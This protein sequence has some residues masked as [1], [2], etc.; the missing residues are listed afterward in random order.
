[1]D[2]QQLL[3]QPDVAGIPG[4]GSGRIAE[5]MAARALQPNFQPIV[6]LHDGSLYGHEALIRTPPGCPW[7]TPDELFAAAREQQLSIE[8]EI[9]CVRQSLLAWARLGSPGPLFLN[10]S[11]A[12]LVTAL[13][14]RDLELIMSLS[15]GSV[16]ATGGV[17]IEL[18]EHEHVADV[19]ALAAAVG[20]LRR[21]RVRVAL[22]DFGDG[23]SSLRL[24][25]EIKPEIVKIDKYFTRDLSN[26]P[27]KLQTL[28]A[29]RQISDTLG[30]ALVAEGIESAVDLHLV[31][32]LGIPLGQGWVFGRPQPRPC[33]EVPL[34]VLKVI[35]SRDVA[36]FPERRRQTQQRANAWT[37]LN[38]APAVTAGTTNQELYGR[39]S[40]DESLQALAIVDD[41]GR[42]LGLVGRQRF[43][44]RYAKPF[45]RE[46]YGRHPCTQ[47]ANLSPRL[48]DIRASIDDLTSVLTSD[49]QRYLSE[50]F[51]IV[52]QGRYR[53]LG[54]G[55]DLVRAVTES[56][57]E[58]AR[59]ANPLT[60]LPGNIPLTQHI[61]RLLT[62][63]REFVACYS[64]LNHFKPFNDQYGYWR[65]DEMIQLAA[66][67]VVAHADARRDF[68][69]HVG[70][71]D[72]VVLFQS[73]DWD[74]RSQ[75]IVDDFNREA[76]ALYDA[77]ARAAGGVMA[78]DRY[79]MQR[80]HPLT[81]MSIGAVRVPAGNG[82][83][84][85]EDVA[86][87]A[88]RAKRQAKAGDA[89]LY[90]LDSCETEPH[91]QRGG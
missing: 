9:E 42:P 63:G 88:A 30:S 13:A 76:L 65:G 56:R 68:V 60:L 2:S 3:F 17:V 66:R 31:R 71:D 50:G 1:M 36:V 78:E 49:D 64:D 5:L 89:G 85:P 4:I 23:R 40:Q 72:F 67:C 73:D 18:T 32:D 58:A 33:D 35:H 79:G 25:S 46:L 77:E 62:A 16:L 24:W 82:T 8:L 53:G 39:F 15:R 59:H 80:F 29:L 27:E 69:G 34:D 90:V 87:A 47:F 10:L 37:L 26:H 12:A 19:D 14:Q 86:N 21:H 22:D 81:T 45:F 75:A 57:I 38:E 7:R 28:R 52:E 54:R 44:D 70:G 74:R 41:D 11:A 48:V 61:Q 84:R 43:V 20:R 51:I 55:E 83:G 91:G 6:Q